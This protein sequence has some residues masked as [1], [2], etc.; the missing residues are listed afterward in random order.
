MSAFGVAKIIIDISRSSLQMS[1]DDRTM[2]QR[3]AFKEYFPLMN[4]TEVGRENAK[5]MVEENLLRLEV[6]YDN[7]NVHTITETAEYSV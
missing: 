7:L 4:F 6:Y 1:I 5:A 3:T 2:F